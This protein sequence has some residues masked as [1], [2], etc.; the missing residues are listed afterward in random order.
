MVAVA[1][2]TAL[3]AAFATT[4]AVFSSLDANPMLCLY[5]ATLTD[6]KLDR[7]W[8]GKNVIVVG[9]SSGIGAELASQLAAHGANLVLT[10]RDEGRLKGVAERCRGEAAAGSVTP[11]RLD[12]TAQGGALDLSVDGAIAALEGD[13]GV[14]VLILN[15]GQGQLLPAVMTPEAT[16]REMMEVNFHCPVRIA[17]RV[18][19]KCQ[20]GKAVDGSTVKGGHV[21]VTSS[22]LA[23]IPGPLSSSYVAA[24]HAVQGYFGTLRSENP[25]LRVDLPCPGPIDTP[26][27]TRSRT[28]AKH[29]AE[30]ASASAN[31]NR[32]PPEEDLS[33]KA[34]MS[35]GRCAR[36][37]LAGMTGPQ[38]L[39][40]ETLI[41][42]QPTLGFAYLTQLLPSVANVILRKVGPLRQRVWEAGLDLYDP[43]SFRNVARIERERQESK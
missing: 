2:A 23:K 27:G 7:A 33:S 3:A 10:G 16:T 37:I 11:L 24:K 19:Q 20:W 25:W 15:A 36:L 4:A 6:A 34:K 5:A 17:S 22:V 8:S 26:F 14:D 12:G 42:R 21:V 1:A 41:M 18:I 9:A 38:A 32:P 29:K 13:G 30:G 39:F 40:Y 31:E 43:A 35:A 28:D